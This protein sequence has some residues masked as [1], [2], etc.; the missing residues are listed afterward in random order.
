MADETI[1]G[2]AAVAGF[3]LGLKDDVTP[4]LKRMRR[5]YA[6]LLD[7]LLTGNIKVQKQIKRTGGILA[8]AAGA[9]AAGSLLSGGPPTTGRRKQ[10]LSFSLD[11]DTKRPGLFRR[12]FGDITKR[13]RMQKFMGSLVPMAEGGMVSKPTAILAG[14]AGKE[15]IIPLDKMEGF[16]L[17]TFD[18]V[19]RRTAEKSKVSVSA[20]SRANAMSATFKTT[21]DLK[22]WIKFI[23]TGAKEG[24]SLAEDSSRIVDALMGAQELEF[25]NARERAKFE[26]ALNEE[27]QKSLFVART[28]SDKFN[29]SLEKQAALEQKIADSRAL[30]Q[31]KYMEA[32]QGMTTALDATAK[33]MDFA[34]NR[35]AKKM[36]TQRGGFSRDE[37]TAFAGRMRGATDLLNPTV[38]ASERLA[39]TMDFVEAGMRKADIQALPDSVF[40]TIAITKRLGAEGKAGAEAFY[41]LNSGA[42]LATSSMELIAKQWT[43]AART[44]NINFDQLAE[45]VG[46][47]GSVLGGAFKDMS[48]AGKQQMILGL[49]NAT[50]AAH[51]QFASFNV[52]KMV[53]ALVTDPNAMANR[54][55]L[56]STSG[57]TGEQ[58]LGS[59]KSGDI[60]GLLTG[61]MTEMQSILRTSTDPTQAVTRIKAQYGNLLGGMEDA[62]I[63]RFAENKD[64]FLQGYDTN[65][66][67]TA[68][69]A[70]GFAE[71]FNAVNGPLD[72]FKTS[73][74]TLVD[75]TYLGNLLDYMHQLQ[76]LELGQGILGFAMLAPGVKKVGGAIASGV[77]GVLRWATAGKLF[78]KTIEKTIDGTTTA[79]GNG[80]GKA[81]KSI[82]AGI[83]SA[84][85]SIGQGVGTLV[86]T[87]GK[88]IGMFIGSIGTGIGTGIT[89]ILTGLAAG[90]TALAP[91][92][93]LLAAPPVLI[94]MAAFTL[95]LIGIGGAVWMVGKGLQAAAPMVTALLGGLADVISSTLGPFTSMDA[96]QILTVATALPLMGVGFTAFATGIVAGMAILTSGELFNKV[97]SFF[98]I[99]SGGSIGEVIS[100]FVNDIS[101]LAPVLS[102]LATSPA[103][104]M[105]SITLPVPQFSG[106]MDMKK[107]R[108]AVA[109][110]LTLEPIV[111]ILERVAKL[112]AEITLPSVVPSAVS[113]QATSARDAE[114]SAQQDMV[115]SL[116]TRIADSLDRA[117]SSSSRA[118][119]S[120]FGGN[121]YDV[122]T[123]RGEL[124]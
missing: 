79:V 39:V 104:G 67:N 15:A 99:G 42:G 96:T 9:N 118:Y 2:N 21:D 89:A 63:L 54:A 92:L 97:A 100:G 82:S 90:L 29:L 41:K 73:V 87:V 94:G 113:L 49:T 24:R 72:K 1:D 7:D 105:K 45:E 120:G 75:K 61:M 74:A 80:V 12:M 86:G 55:L 68:K 119:G 23:D 27:V 6:L 78:G 93:A 31:I 3:Y 20:E 121:V 43:I 77:A 124:G 111:A 64:A 32:L 22:T 57:M 28:Q 36:L 4:Q 122:L 76:I 53:E 103:A 56:G 71:A 58:V 108:E 95:A 114:A 18:N 84:L 44:N 37:V 116:L 40:E 26:K 98:G 19:L 109:M 102:A 8:N 33:L 25:K 34:T 51:T 38:S 106:S 17:K 5:Q 107:V 88:G 13:F 11:A 115:I 112:P 69:A 59:L 60:S 66:N 35:D 123:R 117:M 83:G 46:N 16:F 10:R 52:S 101:G 85:K 110:Y 91:A 81:T 30:Q 47:A 62:D 14:E 65:V 50:A 48:E 70:T